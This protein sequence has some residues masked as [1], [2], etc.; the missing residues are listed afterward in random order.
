M[1]QPST[2][3]P[4][5]GVA[6]AG[7]S[8]ESAPRGSSLVRALPCTTRRTPLSSMVVLQGAGL[9]KGCRLPT[10]GPAAGGERERGGGGT[11]AQEGEAQRQ[12]LLLELPNF[13]KRA[14]WQAGGACVESV[15]T[16]GCSGRSNRAAPLSQATREL[17]RDTTSQF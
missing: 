5:T 4:A 12:S 9:G 16:L 3:S 1:A 11:G 6:R 7:A 15:V 14:E 13:A 17:L 8:R 10:P 2:A